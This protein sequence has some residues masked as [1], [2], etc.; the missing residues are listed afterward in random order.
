MFLVIMFFLVIFVSWLFF[1][2]L[3]S[4][5]FVTALF[6]FSRYLFVLFYSCFWVSRCCFLV[7]DSWFCF[8]KSIVSFFSRF[9]VRDFFGTSILY[10]K[11]CGPGT[12]EYLNL[13]RKQPANQRFNS[14]DVLGPSVGPKK[15][16]STS[17]N[18]KIN[19]V[20]GVKEGGWISGKQPESQMFKYSYVSGHLSFLRCPRHSWTKQTRK[21]QFEEIYLKTSQKMKPP[22]DKQITRNTLRHNTKKHWTHL[23]TKKTRKSKHNQNKSIQ[24][25]KM[26]WWRFVW[27]RLL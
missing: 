14:S 19:H 8:V 23:G 4:S 9:H 21:N 18:L 5:V 16:T 26:Q 25:H 20:L 11:V 3:V 10:H 24:F 17:Q 12:L 27:C 1:R 7:F 13:W 22:H 15:K 6:R 2:L